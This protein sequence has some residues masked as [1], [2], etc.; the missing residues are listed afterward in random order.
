MVFENP[1]TVQKVKVVKFQFCHDLECTFS[2][3]IHLIVQT[4]EAELKPENAVAIRFVYCALGSSFLV[5][6]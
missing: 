6:S 4:Y 1:S 2:D 5:L 3:D